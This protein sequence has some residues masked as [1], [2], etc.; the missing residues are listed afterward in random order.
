MNDNEVENLLAK[1]KKQDQEQQLRIDKIINISQIQD[2]LL[3]PKGFLWWKKCPKCNSKLKKT[4]YYNIYYYN[5]INYIIY[6]NCKKCDYEYS[7][8]EK[9]GL[10]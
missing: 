6:Y 4:Y 9:Q 2:L 10:R 1:K 3:A 8:M 5:S 7:I